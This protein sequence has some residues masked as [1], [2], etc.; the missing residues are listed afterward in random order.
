[1]VRWPS[2]KLLVGLRFPARVTTLPARDGWGQRREPPRP[3]QWAYDDILRAAA[4]H[5]QLGRHLRRAFWA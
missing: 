5:A 2:R 1:M 3:W 4:R